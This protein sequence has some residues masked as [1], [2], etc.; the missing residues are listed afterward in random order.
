MLTKRDYLSGIAAALTE[1]SFDNIQ[2]A[3]EVFKH[4]GID[5]D[6]E[7]PDENG[8][9]LC[10]DCENCHNCVNC[11]ACNNCDGCWC[12]C[13]IDN[14]NHWCMCEDALKNFANR[15]L[16]EKDKKDLQKCLDFANY[17]LRI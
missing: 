6:K 13:G 3:Y 8:N 12:L 9:I 7:T 5:L 16:T 1:N 11:E 2:V 4:F 15:P 17:Y 10:K 14:E